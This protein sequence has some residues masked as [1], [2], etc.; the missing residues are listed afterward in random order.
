MLSSLLA[1]A[2]LGPLVETQLDTAKLDARMLA[3]FNPATFDPN[4]IKSPADLDKLLVRID[5]VD[6]SGLWVVRPITALNPRTPSAL[7]PP[8][9][10]Q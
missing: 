1:L 3:I 2:C 4:T 7:V 6:T 9:T 10:R 5:A 8:K